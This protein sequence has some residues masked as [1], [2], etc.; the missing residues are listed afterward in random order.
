[1]TAA[2]VLGLYLQ[3]NLLLLAGFGAFALLRRVTGAH[4][5]AQ[6]APLLRAAQGLVLLG[7]ALPPLFACLPQE[8]LPRL[9]FAIARPAEEILLP[10]QSPPGA[11]GRLAPKLS[12]ASAQPSA[13][14]A[15]LAVDAAALL[16]ALAVLL[17]AGM[18]ATGFFLFRDIRALNAV[19]RSGA[20]VRRIGRVCV[21][22][23]ETLGS[24]FSARLGLTAYVVVPADILPRAADYRLA[25]RHEFQHHRQG[26][27]LWAVLIEGLCCLFWLN[28]AI[29]AWKKTIVELQEFSCDAALI[30]QRR[31]AAQEYGGC[32]VRVA[33]ATLN[34]RRMP[35]GT[36]CMTA[37]FALPRDSKSFLRRRIEMFT[38]H[39]GKRTGRFAAL[40]LGTLAALATSAAAYAA[41]QAFR[42]ETSAAVNPGQAVF[43]PD[44]QS[45]ATHILS[46]AVAEEKA[47]AGFV[48]V[49]DPTTGK[50]LAAANISNDARRDA[51]PWALSYVLEPASVMKGI[52]AAKAVD[53]HL[54]SF[55]EMLD[56]GNGAYQY[57]ANTIH[58][59]K[60]FGKLSVTDTIVNSSNICGIR[61]S[62]KLGADGLLKT[63]RDLGF[64]PGGTTKDFPAAAP[65]KVPSPDGLP[66]ED[67]IASVGTGYE[68]ETNF[69][70]TPLEIVQAYGAIA[71]GG[72]L[73]KP[74]AANASDSRA[75]ELR[76]V[77]S[78][79]TARGMQAVLRK[80]VTDGTGKPAQSRLY[81]TAGKTATAYNPGSPEHDSLGGE[82]GIASFVGF[83]PVEHPRV[84]IYVAMI[85]PRSSAD[86]N[87]HGSE[88]A[89]PVFRQVAEQVLQHL[90]V[91]PDQSGKD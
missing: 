10:A 40:A 76:Q 27:T 4:A 13:P 34:S 48:I 81:T 14:H 72:K 12:A 11:S 88:H 22:V 44:V 45:I 56:C 66:K 21:V 29:Y 9:H 20:V 84:A 7:L 58:D 28:P 1:M 38:H 33:E 70:V 32:L 16:P 60:P 75:V 3:V 49:A 61:N 53:R 87:P 30:G 23:S 68:T 63:V 19:I 51:K 73:M 24:P 57:G 80:V 43:D 15:S 47:K 55:G 85:E 8:S 86:H 78:P 90:N 91:A 67:Y 64:G 62:E 46:K 71:N 82:R 69:G 41:Q 52:V 17:L 54:V 89:A 83:A 77:L 39:Q 5:A 59:W 2:P 35:V 26:D 31:V 42:P 6:H 18:A 25:L 79:E 50:I 74:L 36:A 37:A 65:G